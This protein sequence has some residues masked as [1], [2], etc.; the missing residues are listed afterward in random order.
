MTDINTFQDILDALEQDPGLGE[1]L[2]QHILSGELRQVPGAVQELRDEVAGLRDDAARMGGDVRRTTGR[3][4]EGYILRFAERL[5]TKNTDLE[6]PTVV[7]SD[8]NGWA[9]PNMKNRNTEAASSGT[10]EFDEADDLEM[11]DVVLSGRTPQGGVRY[12]IIEASITAQESDVLTARRRA[13]LLHRVSGIPTIPAVVS[14]LITEEAVEAAP[15]ADIL[16]IEYN[17]GGRFTPEGART[18]A[19]PA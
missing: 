15:E 9:M 18:A 5:I 17:P 19:A 8:R 3:D 4:Y 14:V 11:A 7:G 12:V 13:E 6:R 1:Q 2:Q 16:F 10:I